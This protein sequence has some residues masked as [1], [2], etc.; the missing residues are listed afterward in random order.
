[1]FLLGAVCG[2][3]GTLGWQTI[4]WFAIKRGGAQAVARA[5]DTQNAPPGENPPAPTAPQVPAIA[6]MPHEPKARSAETQ[7]P[8]TEPEPEPKQAPPP[9]G[10]VTIVEINEPTAT[11]SVPFPMKKGEH[12]VLKGKVKWLKVH[13]LDGGA[14]LDASALEAET[15][16]VGSKID[17]RSTLKVNAPKGTVTVSGKVDGGSRVE[18]NAPGGGVN[19]SVTTTEKRDGSKI[20][21]G[22]V[23]AITARYV[24][25]KGDIAGTDTRVSVVFTRNGFLRFA[26]LS[27]KSILEYRSQVADWSPPDVV[28]GTVA[29]T[30]TFRK[31]E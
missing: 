3:G 6:P 24:E 10:R 29:P 5:E 4:D 13:V 18:V 15:V 7:P 26:S 14:T 17:N 11:Y 19:F 9:P 2:V 1:M 22:S 30:A 8:E 21:G 20:G 16:T 28:A 25:F 31:T 12:V 23:V 27:G